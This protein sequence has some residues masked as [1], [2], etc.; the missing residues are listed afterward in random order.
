MAPMSFLWSTE[1]LSL[2]VSVRSV[3]PFYVMTEPML[4][5]ISSSTARYLLGKKIFCGYHSCTNK[6]VTCGHIC[7]SLSMGVL[8]VNRIIVP[9]EDNR[10]IKS[11]SSIAMKIG[12]YEKVLS[13]TVIPYAHNWL[14]FSRV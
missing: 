5:A 14:V 3:E 7:S 8:L 6:Q 10:S 12:A 13:L 9:L 4:L 2:Y 11:W 1:P